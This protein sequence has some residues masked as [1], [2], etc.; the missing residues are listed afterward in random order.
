MLAGQTVLDKRRV[1]LNI[2]CLSPEGRRSII[3][4]TAVAARGDNAGRLGWARRAVG[5]NATST[6]RRFSSNL[7]EES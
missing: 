5:E 2:Q 3:I 1:Y 7:V 6:G 4:R